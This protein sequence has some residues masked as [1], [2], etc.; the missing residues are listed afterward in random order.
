MAALDFSAD[1]TSLVVI[2]RDRYVLKTLGVDDE[3]EFYD[4]PL[5]QDELIGITE[6]VPVCAVAV[7]LASLSWTC[8]LQTQR[9]SAQITC[10][11][12]EKRED[13]EAEGHLQ[14]QIKRQEMDKRSE[15]FP[16]ILFLNFYKL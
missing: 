12:V 9:D 13:Q 15:S 16:V 1:G 3:S 11:D 5:E 2:Q 8:T 6:D 7:I 10:N 14:L 4:E